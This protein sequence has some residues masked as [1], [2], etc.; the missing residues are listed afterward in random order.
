[1]KVTVQ[2]AEQH[3]VL[4]R[5]VAELLRSNLDSAV[6]LKTHDHDI[7][8]WLPSK[9]TW[10]DQLLTAIGIDP[11][12][13]FYLV[14][15]ATIKAGHNKRACPLNTA[16]KENEASTAIGAVAEN[17]HECS[18]NEETANDVNIESASIEVTVEPFQ[19]PTQT[20]LKH[21]LGTLEGVLMAR[22]LPTISHSFS[23]GKTHFAG[24]PDVQSVISKFNKMS[25][26]EQHR[27]MV[28]QENF[29]QRVKKLKEQLKKLQIK[30]HE[31]KVTNV[32]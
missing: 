6:L 18:V 30:N 16:Q 22:D 15:Y 24:G 12:N 27:N 32:V 25:D 13:S 28:N 7:D 9:S 31:E 2:V 4:E 26:W 10:W 29:K 11:N 21:Q 5:Y 20:Q 1:M 23:S 3:A 14:A 8:R 19:L 17:L